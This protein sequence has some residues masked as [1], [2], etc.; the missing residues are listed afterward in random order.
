MPERC[1]RFVYFSL[2]QLFPT[3]ADYY[4]HPPTAACPIPSGRTHGL[5]SKRKL[6][7]TSDHIPNYQIRTGQLT[8]PR[9]LWKYMSSMFTNFTSL[10]SR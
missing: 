8:F 1:A 5:G 6:I 9:N 4:F 10:L 3:P 2:P 7:Y